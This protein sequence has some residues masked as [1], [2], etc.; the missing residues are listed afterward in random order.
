MVCLTA[1]WYRLRGFCHCAISPPSILFRRTSF[2]LPFW[3]EGRK[4]NLGAGSREQRKNLLQQ[5]AMQLA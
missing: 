4:M 5:K 2:F 3:D 1:Q